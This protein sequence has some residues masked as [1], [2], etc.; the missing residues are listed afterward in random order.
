MQITLENIKKAILDS[1]RS[2]LK[3]KNRVEEG[4]TLGSRVKKE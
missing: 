3:K 2:A 4:R 1:L